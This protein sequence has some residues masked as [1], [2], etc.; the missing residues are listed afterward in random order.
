[1]IK[2]LLLDIELYNEQMMKN[3]YKERKN[4]EIKDYIMASYYDNYQGNIVKEP[5]QII[6][7][8]I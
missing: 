4:T 2:I 6:L 8:F 1:M 7:E 5:E 3:Q